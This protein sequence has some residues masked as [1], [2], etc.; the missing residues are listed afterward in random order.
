M[1]TGIELGLV[2]DTWDDGVAT[3]EAIANALR[4]VAER[5][6]NGWCEGSIISVNGNSIGEYHVVFKEDDEE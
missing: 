2:I 6:E 5:I 4:M 1:S 3:P